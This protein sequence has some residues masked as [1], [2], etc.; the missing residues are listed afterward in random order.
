MKYRFVITLFFICS[1]CRPSNIFGNLVLP[2]DIKSYLPEEILPPSPT[3]FSLGQFGNLA[4]N[5]VNG[6]VSATI[7]IYTF[8]SGKL[9]LPISLNYIS[10]GIKVDQTAS[11]VGLGWNLAAGGLITRVIMDEPDERGT[12]YYPNELALYF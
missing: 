3:A 2:D 11:W 8:N 5:L 1:F 6:A 7:P 9:E 4:P 10:N 12:P